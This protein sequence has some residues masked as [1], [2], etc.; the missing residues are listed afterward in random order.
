MTLDKLKELVKSGE[1]HYV[2]LGGRTGG[3][4]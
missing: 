1:L 3:G 2:Q 4:S